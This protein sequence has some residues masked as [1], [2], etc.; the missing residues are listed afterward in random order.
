MVTPFPVRCWEILRSS[1][2]DAAARIVRGQPRACSAN[3]LLAQPP[4]QIVNIEAAPDAVCELAPQRGTLAHSNHFLNPAGLGV[5]EPLS[6]RRPHSYTR[7]AR[8]RELLEARRP[9]SLA[10]LLS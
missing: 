5:H 2:L 9:L 3:F 4:D 1:S 7:L 10:D 8:M 6:E